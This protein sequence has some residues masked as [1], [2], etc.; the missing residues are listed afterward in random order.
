[1]AVSLAQTTE[2]SAPTFRYKVWIALDIDA[3]ALQAGAL[4][5]IQVALAGARPGTW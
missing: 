4:L 1:M 2:P 3:E 5:A